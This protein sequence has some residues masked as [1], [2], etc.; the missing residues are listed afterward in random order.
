[1]KQNREW[2][3]KVEQKSKYQAAF[4]DETDSENATF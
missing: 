3:D 2:R 1:M 4:Y